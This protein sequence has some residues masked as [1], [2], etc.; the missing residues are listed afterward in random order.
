MINRKIAFIGA[1]KMGSA[2]IK[3]LLKKKIVEKK[4]ILISDKDE[5][6]I[7]YFQSLG[8]SQAG[9]KE[10]A[11]SAEIIFLAVKPNQVEFVCKE[12]QP[13]LTRKH[14]VISIAAGVN[15]K[16]LGQ[17]LKE[18]VQIVR[19]MPNT[20]ALVG[21]GM[22]VYCYNKQFD[23][24]NDEIINIILK[25]VGSVLY[26]EE[27]HF[28]AVTGLSGSGPAYVFLVINSLAEGGVKMGLPKKV[29][30]DLATQTVLGS[31]EMVKK[32]NKHPEDLKEMVTS[33]GG[34]TVEGL[35]VL[36]DYKI[37]S[38]FIQA[39]EAATLKSKNLMK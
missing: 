13:Y 25:A 16:K 39:V 19:I 7:K 35:K 31:A 29:A 10:C 38:A 37:R 18:K 28:D 12:I 11:K 33:P 20:P 1:G 6:R 8:I 21:Q 5:N 22:S 15:I 26:L 23:K 24:K 14:I 34:T 27:K 36:E 3:G 2:L 4:N 17:Y 30:L 32:T 9:N